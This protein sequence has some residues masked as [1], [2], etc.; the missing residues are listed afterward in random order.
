MAFVPWN[1]QPLQVWAR[2]HAP[3]QSI[4]LGGH[5]THYIERGE[6]RPVILIH[7]FFYDTYMWHNNIET[8]ATQFKVYAIDL[9]GF[10]Y[11]TRE[12]LDYGYSLYSQ[13]LLEFMD[14]L[15]IQKASLI[16]QSIGGGA[17]VK[18]ATS[19]RDRIDR[20]ILVAPAGM[21]NPL[22]LMAR[23]ANFPLVGEVMYGLQSDF[24]RKL[25][26]RSN[27]IHNPAHITDAYFQNVTRFHKIRGT[28]EAMLTMLRKRFFDT[29]LGDVQSLRDSD[30]PTLIVWGQEDQSVPV[31]RG[32]TMHAILR[33]SRLHII[34]DA[35]H[36]PH[37]EQS[38]SFNQLALAYLSERLE[39]A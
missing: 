24:M 5:Q 25:A 11:S 29:L 13:Q 15:R 36:C 3:G 17:I 18:F 28:S 39:A 21:P 33:G 26:L 9:W 31:E 16:G 22:P 6:G 34:P 12:P 23:I 2:K 4:T 7:G 14:A 27:F 32:Q 19:H 38:E 8:L 37:D 30:L 35:G 20:A 1:S 10:G